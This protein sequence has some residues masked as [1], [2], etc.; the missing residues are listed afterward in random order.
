MVLIDSFENYQVN[1]WKSMIDTIT[2]IRNPAYMWL[3]LLIFIKIH[4]K[5]NKNY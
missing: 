3:F 5:V 2:D 1:Y 4:R